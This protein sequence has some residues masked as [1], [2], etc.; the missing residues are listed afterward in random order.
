MTARGVGTEGASTPLPASAS[1]RM[2]T[3]ETSARR[4]FRI[5][6][7][8]RARMAAEPTSSRAVAGARLGSRASDARRESA[9]VSRATMGA[10]LITLTARVGA[11]PVLKVGRVGFRA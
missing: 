6:R 4:H 5:A 11:P 8:W 1:A 9:R 10:R 2:A 3:A 7:S